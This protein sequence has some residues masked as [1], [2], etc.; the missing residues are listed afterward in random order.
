MGPKVYRKG[1]KGTNLSAFTYIGIG[2]CP[3]CE[4]RLVQMLLHRTCLLLIFLQPMG[5]ITSESLNF[6]NTITRDTYTT[7]RWTVMAT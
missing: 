1:A 4:C 2:K 5:G 7:A 3:V 6:A